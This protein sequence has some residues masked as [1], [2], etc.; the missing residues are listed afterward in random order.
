MATLTKAP[1]EGDLLKFDLDKNYTREV[2]WLL[3]GTDYGLGSVLG[4]ISSGTASSAAKT[5]NTGIGTLVLDAT[6]PVLSGAKVGTYV[7]SFIS[8]T[9]FT[10]TDPLGDI[11][12]TY[13]IGGVDTNA[14]TVEN[15]IKF[16][17]TQGGTA[18][19]IGDGFDV[20]VANGKGTSAAKSGGNTG[21]GTAVFDAV[22]PILPGAKP[23]IYT[24][25]FT[26]LTEFTITDP[27]GDLVGT[28]TI[29]G[30]QSDDAD[31]A[32]EVKLT[33]TQGS[34]PFAIGDGYTLTVATGPGMY[35]IA[36]ASFDAD[37]PG[38]ERASA[39][40]LT[41]VNASSQPQQ[42]VVIKRGP[43]VVS[44]D[45]LV[46]DSSVDT[47]AKKDAKIAD[48]TALGIVVRPTA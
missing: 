22:T 33:V 8:L 39:V 14:A 3:A 48:L 42:A 41:A 6:T 37:E 46:F 13:A 12:G 4:E 26:K 1:T 16:V 17:L 5:G 38:A 25:T 21:N 44:R 28:Y 11:I 19:A 35:V 23:G 29:G 40:L 30:A 10:L 31:V 32:D 47:D 2:V 15:E 20:T 18:F 7:V 9:S 27:A 36:G 43:A 45:C 24:L 34:T